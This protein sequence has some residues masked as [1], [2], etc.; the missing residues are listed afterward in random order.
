MTT[1]QVASDI[2]GTHRPLLAGGWCCEFWV[3]GKVAHV[4]TRV[5]QLPFGGSGLVG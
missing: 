2:G 1:K 4:C 5:N 3:F